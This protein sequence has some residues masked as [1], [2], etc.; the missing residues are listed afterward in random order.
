[1][2]QAAALSAC[3]APVRSISTSRAMSKYRRNPQRLPAT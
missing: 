1:M 2:G 3:D